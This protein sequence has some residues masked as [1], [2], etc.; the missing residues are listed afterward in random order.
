MTFHI[1]PGDAATGYNIT[2]DN[3]PE[4]GV[5]IK[6]F[7]HCDG[8]TPVAKWLDPQTS[9]PSNP[10]VFFDTSNFIG[11]EFE[12]SAGNVYSKI[13]VLDND[14]LIYETKKGFFKK[15]SSLP[16]EGETKSKNVYAFQGCHYLTEIRASSTKASLDDS[17]NLTATLYKLTGQKE[18]MDPGYDVE[19]YS[20]CE[21]QLHPADFSICTKIDTTPTNDDSVAI[22]D[23][24]EP[25]PATYTYA[26]KLKDQSTFS[27]NTVSVEVIEGYVPKGWWDSIIQ[28]IM[29]TFSLTDRKQAEMI[30]Y[31]GIGLIA[32]LLLSSLF[33]S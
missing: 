14:Y 4:G 17:F 26:A 24:S 5:T 28:F 21:N 22:N 25:S 33:K 2:V 11:Q 29:D 32:L 20:G 27:D 8:L 18:L 16:S 7:I 10:N 6:F 9:A 13:Q 23:H 12:E 31:G 1:K 19:F 3:P 15:G 30:A